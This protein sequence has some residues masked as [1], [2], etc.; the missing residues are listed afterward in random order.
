MHT[1]AHIKMV[2]DTLLPGFLPKDPNEKN[3]VF[4]FTLPPNENY[5][6]SYLKTAKNEWVFSSSEKVDR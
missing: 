3:L 1:E 4:H 5:K 2:A 6:V